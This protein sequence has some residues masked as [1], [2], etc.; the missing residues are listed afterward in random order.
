MR[1]PG[2]SGI[3]LVPLRLADGVRPEELH[4]GELGYAREARTSYQDFLDARA[5]GKLPSG[6]RFQVSVPTPYAVVNPFCTPEDAPK[7][8]PAYEQAML[9]EVDRICA[10]HPARRPHAPVGRLQGDGAVGRPLARS[11]SLPW[12]GAG[13][14]R[15]VRAPLSSSGATRTTPRSSECPEEGPPSSSGW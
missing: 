15:D 12:H 5:A 7:I 6:V 8:L 1:A 13:V 10:P 4:F 2:A 3:Q 9:R 11:S 14:R